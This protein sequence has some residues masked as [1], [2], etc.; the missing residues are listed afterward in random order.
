MDLT[1]GDDAEEMRLDRF[2]RKTLG[3]IG[4]GVLERQLR[5][6]KIRLDG[7]KVKSNTRLRPGQILSYPDMLFAA[8]VPDHL[9]SPAPMVIDQQTALSEVM[10]MVVAEHKDWLALNKVAGLAVQGGSQTRR[11]IDGLLQAA[12]PDARPKLV[13]RLDKDTT[14]LLLV[15][16]H[17]SAAR[18]LTAEFAGKMMQ[19]VYLALVVGDPGTAGRIVAPLR[20]T[21][22]KGA[23]KMVVDYELGQSACTEFQRL[24]KAGPISLVALKPITGR[25]HQL[26]VHMADTGTPIL[27]DGK[28]AGAAAHIGNFSRQLH[29]HARFLRLSDGTTIAADLS[30]HFKAAVDMA[31]L[32]DKL[33]D[34]MSDI[35]VKK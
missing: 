4:Q 14:G 6:G 16:R 1:V 17:D 9:T 8:G 20:K 34:V 32:A 29:L 26:R 35:G 23:E 2:V 30:P 3:P 33:P 7:A 21:A 10:D 19:K 13:H 25:T 28:Y 15:A 22:G 27:G 18:A 11:H 12:Y 5:E 24:G 31:G